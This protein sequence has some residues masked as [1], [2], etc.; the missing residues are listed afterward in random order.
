MECKYCKENKILE[1]NMCFLCKH[2][3]CNVCYKKN[4]YKTCSQCERNI[5]KNCS[6]KAKPGY[7]D[8]YIICYECINGKS[9]V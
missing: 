3:R 7:T 4:I 8:S 1:N 2:S 9:S 5:C 6:S